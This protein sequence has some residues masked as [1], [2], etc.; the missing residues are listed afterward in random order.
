MHRCGAREPAKRKLPMSQ[1]SI[2]DEAVLIQWVQKFVRY[3]S[4]QTARFEQEPEVQG[5]IAD[6]VMP[7]IAELNL[8]MRRDAMGNLLV[9]IGPNNADASLVLMAYAMTH[10]AAAMK[11]PFAGELIELPGG[12][13]VR[14][15]G[16]SE[17]KGSLTAALAATLAAHRAGALKGRSV[18]RRLRGRHV[19]AR[20]DGILAFERGKHPGQRHAGGRRSLSCISA[21]LSDVTRERRSGLHSSSSKRPSPG[22]LSMIPF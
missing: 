5:F 7:L 14:G 15:R 16:I 18:S 11:N 17:Q 12:K 2:V 9:E 13:A 10:P 6:C 4:Q 19:G 1:I 3:P 21:E 22:I 8:P 20:P